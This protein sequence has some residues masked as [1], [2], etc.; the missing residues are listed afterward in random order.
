MRIDW[1]K[2]EDKNTAF[3]HAQ[4]PKKRRKNL[5]KGLMNEAGIWCGGEIELNRITTDYFKGIFKTQFPNHFGD[6]L[7]AMETR[8]TDE[9]NQFLLTDFTAEE[10]QIAI[11]Q[12]HPTKTPGLDGMPTLFYQKY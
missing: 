8:V 4:A 5:I 6:F 3:F 12:M 9:M 11:K 10:I 7:D 2:D 1:L